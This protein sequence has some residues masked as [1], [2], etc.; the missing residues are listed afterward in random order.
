[1]SKPNNAIVCFFNDRYFNY[2]KA[3]FNSLKSNYPDHPA[4]LVAYDGHCR[5]VEA[6]LERHQVT[7]INPEYPEIHAS[8]NRQRIKDP[9][10]F[11]RFS[12]WTDYFD[13]YDNLLHLDIDTLVLGSLDEMLSSQDFFIVSNHEPSP[14]ARVFRGE[15]RDNP[16]LLKSLEQDSLPYPDGMDDMA[17]AG[18]FVIPRKYRR[19]AELECLNGLFHRYGPYV[20]YADQSLIS[21][22]CMLRGIPYS[23]DFRYNCQS[24]LLGDCPLNL[25]LDEMRLLHFSNHKPDSDAFMTWDRIDGLQPELRHLYETYLDMEV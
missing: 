1:M 3:C 2:F 7:R 18:I 25:K 16:E 19:P 4:L 8:V 6:F 14:S 9:I 10:V 22:W 21:L 11:N 24:P 20:A 15:Y 5:Q 13:D 23:R 12:M 17:N